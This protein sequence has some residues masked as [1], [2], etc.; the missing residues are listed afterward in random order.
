IRFIRGFLSLV[1]AEGRAGYFIFRAGYSI[2]PSRLRK[3]RESSQGVD[4]AISTPSRNPHEFA[5][6]VDT[7]LEGVDCLR[8]RRLGKNPE[9]LPKA[10]TNFRECAHFRFRG[11]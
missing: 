3:P 2:S 10:L 11:V 1:A 4:P 5:E 7:R 9:N 6:G 8:F